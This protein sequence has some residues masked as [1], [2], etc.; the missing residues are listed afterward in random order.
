MILAKVSPLRECERKGRSFLKVW[1]A[2]EQDCVSLGESGDSVIMQE[3][4]C[5]GV[6]DRQRYTQLGKRKIK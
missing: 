6:I 1:V 2:R 5:G 4:T 3:R